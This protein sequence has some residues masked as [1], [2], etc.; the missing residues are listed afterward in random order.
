MGE[1]GKEYDWNAEWDMEGYSRPTTSTRVLGY[2]P[3]VLRSGSPTTTETVGLPDRSVVTVYELWS[4][5]PN[6]TH[7]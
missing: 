3:R 1:K 4:G 5:S 2:C 7:D 6:E